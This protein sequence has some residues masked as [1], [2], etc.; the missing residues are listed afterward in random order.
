MERFEHKGR[1]LEFNREVLNLT[2]MQHFA[3]RAQHLAELYLKTKFSSLVGHCALV[4][5]AELGSKCL[6]GYLER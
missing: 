1:R 5:T 2:D 6:G 4:M 3:G